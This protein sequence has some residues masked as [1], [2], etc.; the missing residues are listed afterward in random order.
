MLTRARTR[1]LLA[2]I[3]LAL[4]P[5]LVAATH[6]SRKLTALSCGQ[7]IIANTTLDADLGPCG[8]VGVVINAD[9]V[10]L[11]LNGHHIRGNGSNNPGVYSN[12][13]GV[14]VENGWVSNFN[15][16]VD[17]DGD[18]SRVTNLRASAAVSAGV[19]TTGKNDVVSSNRA[20]G[21]GA[22]GINGSGAGSQY[23]NNILQ[24]NGAFGMYAPDAA[25][26][27]GNKALN[28]AA[29]GIQVTN[30]AGAA[31]TM[32]NNITNGNQLEGL[33]ENAGDPTVVTLTGNQAYFNGKL[34]I[35]AQPGVNDGGHNKADSNGTAAQCTNVVCS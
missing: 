15:I 35:R 12:R 14:V 21:N 5:L 20:F 26:V 9:H 29:A 17:L 8:A 24:S 6:G 22:N 23:T 13:V 16:N 2:L 11:N 19:V 4:V 10:T 33:F 31:M 34:G 28:N 3:P 27:S 7:T 32:T 1:A 25:L 30:F 18:S